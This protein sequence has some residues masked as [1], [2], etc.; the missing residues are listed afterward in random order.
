MGVGRWLSGKAQR[1][2]Q[3]YEEPE[4]TIKTIIYITV[5]LPPAPYVPFSLMPFS[6]ECIRVGSTSLLSR[7]AYN[8]WPAPAHD[9][10]IRQDEHVYRRNVTLDDKEVML[11]VLDGDRFFYP[12]NINAFIRQNISN[13]NGPSGILFVYDTTSYLSWEKIKA[14]VQEATKDPN[15]R[16]KFMILGCKCDMVEQK[17]VDF[18]IV[19]EFAWR[20]GISFM[21]TSAKEKYNVDYAFLSFAAQLLEAESR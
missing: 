2:G 1:Q 7:F 10:D 18:E 12:R 3:E 16:R 13:K 9:I 6:A 8:Y 15:D 5:V 19:Q 21:E 14:I 17:Q 20:L 11:S 4:E